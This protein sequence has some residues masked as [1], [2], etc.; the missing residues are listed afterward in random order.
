MRGFFEW[1]YCTAGPSPAA[2]NS[3]LGA[4]AHQPLEGLG[5]LAPPGFAMVSPGFRP[6]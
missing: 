4:A 2:T 6:T 3:R 1:S 5:Q